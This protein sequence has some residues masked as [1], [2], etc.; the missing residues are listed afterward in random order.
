MTL[1]QYNRE[2]SIIELGI[3]DYEIPAKGWVIAPG[4]VKKAPKGKPGPPGT[5]ENGATET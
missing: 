2:R 3:K 4:Q 5:E 1:I